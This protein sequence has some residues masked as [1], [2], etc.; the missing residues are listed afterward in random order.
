MPVQVCTHIEKLYFDQ[1]SGSVGLDRRVSI[2]EGRIR[3]HEF[4]VQVGSTPVENRHPLVEI[5]IPMHC[6]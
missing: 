3:V 5:F 6:P 4:I 1:V 2:G